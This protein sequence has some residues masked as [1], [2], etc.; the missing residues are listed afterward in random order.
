MIYNNILNINNTD[1]YSINLGGTDNF[2]NY[3]FPCVLKCISSMKVAVIELQ[4]K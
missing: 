1:Y 3:V 4:V 2:Q